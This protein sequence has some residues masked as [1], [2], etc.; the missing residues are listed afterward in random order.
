VLFVDDDDDLRD[1]VVLYLRRFGA[2][3][4]EASNGI[5]A[6][7]VFQHMDF[8]VVLSD[9]RMPNGDGLFL[10]QS[11]QKSGKRKPV[12]LIFSGYNDLTAEMCVES[13]ITESIQK[14]TTMDNIV[15]RICRHLGR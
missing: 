8:D 11:I 12:F 3:V 2:F 14:P 5:S 4:S 7:E 13:G 10:A 9:M 1:A 6:F 15:G